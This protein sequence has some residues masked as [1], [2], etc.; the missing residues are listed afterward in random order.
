MFCST[1][2]ITVMHHITGKV[3]NR[4]DNTL[5]QNQRVSNITGS[6]SALGPDTNT[7]VLFLSPA[8]GTADQFWH[9]TCVRC[10]TTVLQ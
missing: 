3:P 2:W 7:L 6:L 8:Q 5:A 10:A 4:S 1:Q 9:L